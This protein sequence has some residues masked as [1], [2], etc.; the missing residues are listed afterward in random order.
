M[1]NVL[2][3]PMGIGY[4]VTGFFFFNR[5]QFLYGGRA[6]YFC[7]SAGERVARIVG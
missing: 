3:E 5:F 4:L 1:F 6:S 7:I 2:S